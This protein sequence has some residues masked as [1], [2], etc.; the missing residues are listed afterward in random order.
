MEEADDGVKTQIN[1]VP[2]RKPVTSRTVLPWHGARD[3]MTVFSTP[4]THSWVRMSVSV[5]VKTKFNLISAV[6][7]RR[8]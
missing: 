4:R 6:D 5:N 8:G 3:E 1:L 7:V 2:A